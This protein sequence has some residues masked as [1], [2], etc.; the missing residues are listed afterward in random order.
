MALSFPL[1][2][3]DSDHY[4]ANMHCAIGAKNFFA[5]KKKPSWLWFWRNL[6]SLRETTSSDFSSDDKLWMSTDVHCIYTDMII[7][8][9]IPPSQSS[10]PLPWWQRFVSFLSH[11]HPDQLLASLDTRLLAYEDALSQELGQAIGQQS[12][13]WYMTNITWIYRYLCDQ[14][15]TARKKIKADDHWRQ[16]RLFSARYGVNAWIDQRKQLPSYGQFLNWLTQLPIHASIIPWVQDS[17]PWW[18][19]HRGIRLAQAMAWQPRVL[20]FLWFACA[21]V[22][23]VYTSWIVIAVMLS[24]LLLLALAHRVTLGM[25]KMEA[26]RWAWHT[27]PHQFLSRRTKLLY[28]IEKNHDQRLIRQEAVMMQ[29]LVPF[30]VQLSDEMTLTSLRD[31]DPRMF[32]NLVWSYH[33]LG[34]WWVWSHRSTR[35]QVLQL[36]LRDGWPIVLDDETYTWLRE[37]EMA[38]KQRFWSWIWWMGGDVY[39]GL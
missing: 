24:L 37:E 27:Q 11:T 33:V 6:V 1:V 36:L 23:I 38:M 14:C 7:R 21:G 34:L 35:L 29:W 4:A 5:H 10:I 13:P 3:M 9:E 20:K 39:E 12:F 19:R 25:L 17:Q 26:N 32:K 28:M 30:V 2:L 15:F 8:S 31:H 22:V 18:H 16:S